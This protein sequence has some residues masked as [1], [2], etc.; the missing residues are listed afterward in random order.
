MGAKNPSVLRQLPKP[1][2]VDT[3]KGKRGQG[4]EQELASVG[5][6]RRRRRT[7]RTAPSVR[8][9]RSSLGVHIDAPAAKARQKS[10]E[11]KK[12]KLMT[13]HCIYP[14][15]MMVCLLQTETCRLWQV[16]GSCKKWKGEYK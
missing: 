7:A 10:E 15:L 16:A 4:H 6:K 5:G 13:R 3:Q 2:G 8:I 11:S 14:C 12:R 9:R 1:F